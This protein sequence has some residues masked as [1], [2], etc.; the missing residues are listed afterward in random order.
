MTRHTTIWQ[1]L[2][3]LGLAGCQSYYPYGQGGTGPY[4]AMPAGAYAPPGA[5][6]P[7]T[8]RLGP[9][10]TAP[11][12][13]GG[14]GRLSEAPLNSQPA[15]GGRKLV[16][17]DPAASGVPAHLGEPEG[18]DR[19]RR[20]ESSYLDDPAKRIDEAADE[21]ATLA[22]FDDEAFASPQPVRS[23]VAE[24]DD[25]FPRQARKPAPNPYLRDPTGKYSWLRGK[26]VRDARMNGWRLRYSDDPSDDDRHG[27]SL[28]LVGNEKI[29]LLKED[30][31]I[32]VYGEIDSTTTDRSGR[33]A[34]HVREL[35][36]LKPR[37]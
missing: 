20:N 24:G 21:G 2:L 14:A 11:A 18:D 23:A 31:V 32:V 5:A 16:P 9:S 25:D 34:Y 27:G 3:L 29:D 8:G 37:E 19:I 10:A 1:G 36:K 30:D 13:P 6:L 26:V 4:P 22:A 17:S 7:P 33:P 35:L 15:A 28:L 12:S